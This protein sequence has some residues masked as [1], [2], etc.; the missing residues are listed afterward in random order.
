MLVDDLRRGAYPDRDVERQLQ[1]PSVVSAR[2]VVWNDDNEQMPL[3][4]WVG[5]ALVWSAV[6]VFTVDTVRARTRPQPI[7]SSIRT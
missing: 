1:L 4:R 7:R 2:V 5:F 6:V 3:S